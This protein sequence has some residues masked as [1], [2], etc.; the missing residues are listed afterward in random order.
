[1]AA[2]ADHQIGTAA[3]RGI[4]RDAGV[5]Q[6]LVDDVV[7]QDASTSDM[8][9]TGAQLVSYASQFVTLVPGDIIA[10]GTPGGIGATR[11][12]PVYL[13]DGQTMRTIVEGIGECVNHCVAYRS[14]R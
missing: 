11:K 13:H 5:D 14:E 1:M 4:G 3:D 12:P 6:C 2:P 7:M 10:T 9:Y 8:L